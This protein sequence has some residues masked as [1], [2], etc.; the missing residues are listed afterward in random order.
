MRRGFSYLKRRIG[1]PAKEQRSMVSSFLKAHQNTEAVRRMD[2]LLTSFSAIYLGISFLIVLYY[3][4]SDPLLLNMLLA[5]LALPNL[6]VLVVLPVLHTLSRY[7]DRIDGR[8]AV[9]KILFLYFGNMVAILFSV[10]PFTLAESFM[11]L[12]QTSFGARLAD[13]VGLLL[14]FLL[15]FIWVRAVYLLCESI[16][17]KWLESAYQSS[18]MRSRL[19]P[20]RDEHEP[21]EAEVFIAIGSAFSKLGYLIVFFTI[22]NSAFIISTLSERYFTE[23]ADI[24]FL[25]PLEWLTTILLVLLT[26]SVFLTIIGGHK[27][28]VQILEGHS[29]RED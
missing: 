24:L 5:N 17:I 20:N 8:V 7:W 10:L 26:R 18:T 22:F 11:S 23:F 4:V 28:Q 3:R 1:F 21:S 15:V 12:V 19:I 9:A 16:E 6:L 29:G 27:N 25:L 13:L 14:F 2:L